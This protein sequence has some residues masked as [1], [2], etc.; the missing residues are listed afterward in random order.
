MYFDILNCMLYIFHWPGRYAG[1]CVCV[2]AVV[3]MNMWCRKSFYRIEMLLFPKNDVRSVVL[4]VSHTG[5]NI[6]KDGKI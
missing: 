2:S 3:F 6:C 4:E 1:V 5:S